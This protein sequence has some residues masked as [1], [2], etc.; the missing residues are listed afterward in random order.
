MSSANPAAIAP[1]SGAANMCDGAL[2]LDDRPGL[3]IE[4]DDD[5]CRSHLADGSGYFEG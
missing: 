5:F 3:G 1:N 2:E 4:L